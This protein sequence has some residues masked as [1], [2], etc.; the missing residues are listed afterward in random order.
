M[1]E[2]KIM[3]YVEKPIMA[4]AKSEKKTA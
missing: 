4:S 3:A 2:M 1:K